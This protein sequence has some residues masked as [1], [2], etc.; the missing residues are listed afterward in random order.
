MNRLIRGITLVE[1]LVVM[2]ILSL[3]MLMLGTAI[4]GVNSMWQE[5]MGINPALAQN[6]TIADML[7]EHVRNAQGCRTTGNPYYGEAIVAASANSITYVTDKD[8]CATVRY[9][10][11]GTNLMRQ[12][13]GG[14]ATVAARGV[15]SLGWSYLK[16]TAY[17]G[18]WSS[19]SVP[20]SPASNEL[21][22]LSGVKLH[23][24]TS[25]NGQSVTSDST[26]R[27]RNSPKKNRLDGL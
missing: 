19:T 10:I 1:T 12:I 27:L 24:V 8:T 26:I 11:S 18:G 16:S 5:V 4:N 3:F 22:N 7:S 15:T 13:N 2:V 9:Y 14:Q 25:S 17:F 21:V 6:R 23:L 20:T